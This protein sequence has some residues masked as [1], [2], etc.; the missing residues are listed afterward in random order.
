MVDVIHLMAEQNPDRFI[1]I[2]G[3][4]WIRAEDSERIEYF[5]KYVTDHI[6]GALLQRLF[7]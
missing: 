3:D 7:T 4:T 5:T 2:L 6:E 1:E